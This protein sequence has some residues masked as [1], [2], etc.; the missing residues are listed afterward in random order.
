MDDCNE[1]PDWYETELRVLFVRVE[2]DADLDYSNRTPPL[3]RASQTRL[4]FTFSV[5]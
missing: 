4:T 2:G 3:L 5:T 1:W